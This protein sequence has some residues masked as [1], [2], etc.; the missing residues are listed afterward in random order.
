MGISTNRYRTPNENLFFR[1]HESAST[2][3]KYCKEGILYIWY[4]EKPVTYLCNSEPW[5]YHILRTN[6]LLFSKNTTWN[7]LKWSIFSNNGMLFKIITIGIIM[8]SNWYVILRNRTKSQLSRKFSFASTFYTMSEFL[9]FSKSYSAVLR[10]VVAYLLSSL[11]LFWNEE[12][13]DVE[14]FRN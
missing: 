11:R 2:P 5:K 7:Q 6:G 8:L 10:E 14:I 9:Y 13:F 1:W 4:T 12:W 3:R